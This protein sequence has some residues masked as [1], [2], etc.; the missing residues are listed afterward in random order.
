ML[1]RKKRGVLQMKHTLASAIIIT[2]KNEKTTLK[3][4]KHYVEI[5]TLEWYHSFNSLFGKTCEVEL[6]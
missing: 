6:K 5:Y 2:Q 4:K 1:M 3:I